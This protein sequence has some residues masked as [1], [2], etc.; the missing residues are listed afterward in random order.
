M[1]NRA[2]KYM[3]IVLTVLCIVLIVL[4][5]IES[6]YINPL[7]NAVGYVLVPIQ[8]GINSVGTGIYNAV[9]DAESLRNASRENQ[10]LRAQ[11][12]T[13]LEE[14]NR[15]KSD[16]LELARLRELYQ[17]DQDYMQYPKV[18]ARVIAKDS[19]K[20]FQVFRI[21]KGSAD[22][23]EPDMNVLCGGG[24][25]G[26]VTDV[27]ANYATVRSII[28]D[29]SRVSAMS[30]VSADTCIVAG[31]LQ[32]FEDG[33]LRIS[34]IDKNAGISDG[35]AIVTS[36]I[37]TKFLPGILIGYAADIQVDAQQLTKSG[38]LIPVA[39]FDNLQEVFV[40]TQKKADMQ[41]E[42]GEES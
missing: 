3:L 23:I 29:E 25:L 34:N 6:G 28:D 27:G 35:D 18:A 2:S 20:W 40:I 17:L 12:D 32:L 21:D 19:E 9:S 8:K 4:S 11:I 42:G 31:D 22:G 41:Q 37:S 26:I 10:E 24:L 36:N 13:L 39:D 30:Q 16:T 5:S 1:D 15:L 14:N 33:R 38:T 7:R